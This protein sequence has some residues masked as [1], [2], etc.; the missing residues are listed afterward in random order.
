[1]KDTA[2]SEVFSTCTFSQILESAS[3]PD[4]AKALREH[5]AFALNNS[6]KTTTPQGIRDRFLELAESP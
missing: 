5:F 2:H 3:G 6:A 4:A 1:M